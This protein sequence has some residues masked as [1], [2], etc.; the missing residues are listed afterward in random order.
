MKKAIALLLALIM[1]LALCVS[2]AADDVEYPKLKI[3][4]AHINAIDQ[5]IGVAVDKFAKLMNERSGGNITVDVYPAGSLYDQEGIYDAIELGN[6]DMGIGDVSGIGNRVPAFSLYALPFLYD[7]YETM[8]KIVDGEVGAAL[9]AQ[10]EE[11]MGAIALGWGWNGFRNMVTNDPITCIDDC[12]NYLL[13]SP[14]I[15]LYLETF[16]LLGM[17]P[18]IIPWGDAFTGMQSGVCDGVETT[19]EAIYTQGFYTVGNNVCLS[20]HMLSI[21]GPMMNKDLWD[22]LDENT[23]KLI[24]DTWME[25]RAEWN[26]TVENSEDY[27][28][29]LLRDEGCNITVFEDYDKVVE[30]FT[31]FWKEHAEAG[32][33]TELLDMAIA[34]MG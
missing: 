11:Q 14:G 4:F 13:R 21:I 22:S 33:Y 16:K 31:P 12:K 8:A 19:T 20:R 27:Y 26:E 10:L 30:L 32:G 15:D 6:L 5:P 18:V 25:V 17:S 9:D 2:A 28:V 7:S 1:V 34:C 3:Q 23:Q 29:Q 24:K